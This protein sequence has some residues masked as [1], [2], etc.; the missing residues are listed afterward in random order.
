VVAVPP[1]AEVG[2]L[3]SA[4]RRRLEGLAHA[5]GLLGRPWADLRRQA[6]LAAVSAARDYLRLRGEPLPDISADAGLLL[7]GHQPELFHPGVW[8]KNF[9]LRGLARA[10]GRTALNLV[11][12]NDTVKTTALRV[13][14]PAEGDRPP[15]L[16]SVPFDRWGGGAPYE[17]RAVADRDLF[18]TFSDRVMQLMRG[19][20]YEPLLPS[21]WAEVRRRE[22]ETGL[23][24]ESFASARRGLERAWGCHNLEVPLSALCR[25]EP[26]AWFAAHLLGELPRFGA[27]YNAAVHDYRA[28]NGIRSANHPV[29]DLAAEDDWHE[30]PFWGWRAGQERRGRLFARR[31]DGRIELRAG[32]ESWPALPAPEPGREAETVAAWAALEGQGFKARSRALTTTLFARLFLGELFIHG[33]GGGKYDELT[34]ELIRRFYGAEPPAFLVLSATLWLPLGPAPA[35]DLAAERRRL[36]R[37]VRDVYWNPQRHL[38]AADHDPALAALAAEKADWIARR[39]AS[40]AERRRRFRTLRGLTEQ[41][42]QP[43][44]PRAGELVQELARCDSRLK[45]AAVLRRRDYSF[46]LHPAD[47][48]RPFC[49]QFLGP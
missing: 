21:L 45:A 48:L 43:L 37:A 12:D 6:R 1:L 27:V 16:A 7:A 23:L 11:V 47:T 17:G 9:A 25:T 33:I 22:K 10:H 2:A 3:L 31:R 32:A 4:N 20:G 28:R 15:R 24:G 46:C 19:W 40:H 38:D 42:R 8:I 36:A 35:A 34:D 13:P 14:V 30:A 18:D 49:A 26:F 44:G 39:P 5:P 41:L 29:P